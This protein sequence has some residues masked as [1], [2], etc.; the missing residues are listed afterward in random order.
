M[1]FKSFKSWFAFISLC[2][3][4]S[5]NAAGLAPDLSDLNTLPLHTLAAPVVS[6][7]ISAAVS[8]SEPLQFAVGIPL[9]LNLDA[10]QWQQTGEVSRWRTRIRSQGAQTLNFTFSKFKLPPGASLWIY[11]AAG[12]L[13]QGPYTQANETPEG[14]LWTPVIAGGDAVIELRVPTA[15]RDAVQLQLGT[16]NHGF[17]GFEKATGVESKAGA[18]EIDVVCPTGDAWRNE[19]RSVARISIGGTTLCSGQL[20]NNVAQNDTPYFLTANHCNIGAIPVVNNPASSVVFY[21]NYQTSVCSGARNGSLSQNQTGSSLIG[22]D[23]NSD[24][25]L[26]QVN[27]APNPAFN[28]HLSGWNAGGAAVATASSPGS[29]I[30]HPTG[31]EKSISLFTTSGVADNIVL[32]T[33]PLVGGICA[34][35]FSRNVSVWRVTYSQGVTEPG[36]SG[37]GLWDANHQIVGQLSGGG[38]SCS[39]PTAPDYYGRFDLAFT[40]NSNQLKNVLD[41]ANTG[42][43]TLCGKDFSAASCQTQSGSSTT[44]PLVTAG[45]A[46]AGGGGGSGGGALNPFLL[47]GLLAMSLLRR[48]QMRI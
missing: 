10:G 30:H 33:Q 28:L 24:Y 9:A 40:A 22:G 41:P 34:P 47:L 17:R 5:A 38:S 36:S 32:C 19:I 12:E 15:L 4:G 1:R 23:Q 11:D 46:A 43:K 25:T 44:V 7:A 18:C 48:R 37:G 29:V 13:V 42:T 16:V 3:L 20:L 31:S 35:T 21:W 6:K 27:T 2:T 14:M 39:A 26:V 45:A 8:K